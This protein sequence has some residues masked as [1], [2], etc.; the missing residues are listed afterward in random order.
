LLLTDG[1]VEVGNYGGG[2]AILASARRVTARY[3]RKA[4][5][6]HRS[7][8]HCTEVNDTK[9][10]TRVTNAKDETSMTHVT[11]VKKVTNVTN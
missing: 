8:V 1:N 2:G 5:L 4:I 10:V 7:T 9:Q 6:S 3:K 11:K